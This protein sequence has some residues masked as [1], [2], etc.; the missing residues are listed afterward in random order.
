MEAGVGE[1]AKAEIIRLHN[2]AL[3]YAAA[4]NIGAEGHSKLE[5][6]AKSLLGR[7]K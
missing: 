2:E 5:H 4:L 7:A 3:E 1:A 6:Y